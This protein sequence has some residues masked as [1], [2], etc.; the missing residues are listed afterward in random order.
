MH[1][2]V[3]KRQAAQQ[4]YVGDMLPVAKVTFKDCSRAAKAAH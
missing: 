1:T 2:P 3:A 4:A